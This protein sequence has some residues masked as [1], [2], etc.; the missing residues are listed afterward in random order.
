MSALTPFQFAT[1]LR[2]SVAPAAGASSAPA[3]PGPVLNWPAFMIAGPPL[4]PTR[5]PTR[6][7]DYELSWK[8]IDESDRNRFR[9]EDH[10]RCYACNPSYDIILDVYRRVFHSY[11][12]D[13]CEGRAEPPT[14]HHSGVFQRDLRQAEDDIGIIRSVP[15]A[16]PNLQRANAEPGF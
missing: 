14:D 7:D 8:D 4:E 9:L 5:E 3:A 10:G 1:L 11:S 13:V 2:N 12:E 15:P 16:P 6:P